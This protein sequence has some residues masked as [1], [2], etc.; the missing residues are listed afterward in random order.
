MGI[1]AS[2]LA[3]ALAAAPAAPAQT[4]TGEKIEQ[5]MDKT[6]DKAEQKME[7]AG[8][9]VKGMAKE[10]KTGASDSWLTAKTKIALFADDRVKGRQVNVETTNGVVTLRGKV[11]S[12]EAKSAAESITKTV[13]GVRSVRNELQV[14]TPTERPM[15]D[16]NDGDIKKTIE[17][18]F[19]KDPSLGKIDVRADKG[20]VT[21]TGEADGIGTSARASEIARNVPGV[22]AVKND[23]TF[24]E[25]RSDR[26]MRADRPVASS[27]EGAYSSNRQE[28]VRLMQEALKKEGFDPGPID[29]IQGPQTTAAIE[30]YQKAENLTVTGRADA[31]T[32]GKLKISSQASTPRKRPS[33]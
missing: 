32:L 5:K 22:R 14:V 24:K 8:D 2:V 26:D 12:A 20:V 10:A 1:S 21:L 15:V 28:H 13:D 18:S 9:S 33:P 7:K 11:D 30:A 23:V 17:N 16:A 29:G 19:A 27:S 6:S 3:A 4:T 25:A 31:E